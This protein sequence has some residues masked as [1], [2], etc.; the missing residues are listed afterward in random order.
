MRSSLAVPVLQNPESVVP[1]AQCRPELSRNRRH[2][3]PGY[4]RNN[5]SVFHHL[6][7]K[8]DGNKREFANDVAGSGMAGYVRPLK[9]SG[10]EGANPVPS[11]GAHFPECYRRAP[12]GVPSECCR[13]KRRLQRAP[14]LVSTF[15]VLQAVTIATPI[16]LPSR[17]GV[18]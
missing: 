5:Y 18:V 16:A 9:R 8:R 6:S 15:P 10:D 3:G 2:L 14:S 4:N 7:A 11:S 17:T 13:W 1:A 12:V